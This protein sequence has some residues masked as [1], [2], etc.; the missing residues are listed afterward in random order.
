MTKEQWRAVKYHDA[1]YD[2]LLVY[3]KKGGKTFCRPSCAARTVTVKT[4]LI[5]DSAEAARAAGYRPCSRCHPELRQWAGAKRELARTA[6]GYIRD[7]SAEKFSLSVMAGRLHVDKS[8]LLRT[9]REVTGHTLLAYHNLVRC[10]N[11]RHL[12]TRPEL[13]VSYIASAV[14]YVSASHFTQ[15]FRKIT[16]MTPTQYRNRYLESLEELK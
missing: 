1:A 3:A 12:L 6:E 7:H 16:G 14:G 5:F 4:V 9:F 11:A 15:I 13:S 10:E 2:G 8:Y